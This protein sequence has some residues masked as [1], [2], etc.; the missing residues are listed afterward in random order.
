[1][2]IRQNKAVTEFKVDAA[3]LRRLGDTGKCVSSH[4]CS[5]GTKLYDHELLG[6]SVAKLRASLKARAAGNVLGIPS[7]CIPALAERG[8]I[9]ENTDHDARLMAG[10]RLYTL[11]S[12]VALQEHL[13]SV[14]TG[15][16]HGG[17]S[18]QLVMRNLLHA[19]HWADM[20][21]ALL[22]KSLK[23]SRW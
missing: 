9:E 14:A 23:V 12:I 4:R 1:G 22:N 2:L 19:E 3:T 7:H 17:I 18:I 10:E 21:E 20:V 15:Q 5:T 11:A 13:R 8:L 16:V 6:I